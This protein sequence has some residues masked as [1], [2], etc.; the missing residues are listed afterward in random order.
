M[1][2]TAETAETPVQDPAP[3][4]QPG[5]FARALDLVRKLI[6]Y[7]KE[8][9]ATVLQRTGRIDFAA[10]ACNFGTNDLELIVARITQG[11]LRARALEERLERIAPKLDASPKPA[12]SQRKPRAAP[13]ARQ[14]EA[15]DTH[16]KQLPTPERIAAEVRRKPIGAVIADICR[17]LGILPCHP[18]WRELQH[19]IIEHGG[20][21][22]A[23][24][25]DVI[26][27]PYPPGWHETSAAWLPPAFRSP[28]PD[29]TGPPYT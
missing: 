7:G 13:A 22:A 18:L 10:R 17:D 14:T 1:F 12:P 25:I 28:A 23:L 19:A 20:N 6:D 11:L 16:L 2:M 9:A 15:A 29:G 8:L 27:R 5:R 21:Y 3:T 26:M 24:V 4:T